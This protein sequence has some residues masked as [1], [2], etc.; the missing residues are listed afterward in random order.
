MKD[1][2][3]EGDTIRGYRIYAEARKISDSTVINKTGRHRAQR[4]IL[5]DNAMA[6]IER[7]LK[8]L[9]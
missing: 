1:H 9:E 7:K 6:R 2:L 8:W 5:L 4:V 3:D